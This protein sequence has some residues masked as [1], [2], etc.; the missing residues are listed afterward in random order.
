MPPINLSFHRRQL[1]ELNPGGPDLFTA[2]SDTSNGCK[3]E[4]EK[5]LMSRS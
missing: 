2:E 4:V 5:Q 1:D 3:Q